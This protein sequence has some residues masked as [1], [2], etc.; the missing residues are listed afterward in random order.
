M[1]E[2]SDSRKD[3]SKVIKDLVSD[4]LT[5]FPE[6]KEKMKKGGK[7]IDDVLYPKAEKKER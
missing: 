2:T 1:T 6:L 4:V 3:F 7:K 5:T